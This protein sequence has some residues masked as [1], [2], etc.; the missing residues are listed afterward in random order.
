MP[1]EIAPFTR[2]SLAD[3]VPD[4]LNGAA[5]RRRVLVMVVAFAVIALLAAI[6]ASVASHYR[7]E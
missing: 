4:F 6:V 2:S 7:P 3:E 5:R 1:I